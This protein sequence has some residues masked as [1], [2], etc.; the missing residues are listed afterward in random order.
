MGEFFNSRKEIL[1]PV[2]DKLFKNL[3]RMVVV[4]LLE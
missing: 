1:K 3:M 4:R 2:A